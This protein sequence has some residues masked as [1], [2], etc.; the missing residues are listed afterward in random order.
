MRRQRQ[1]RQGLGVPAEPYGFSNNAQ[2][3][4]RPPTFDDAAM[5]L[6]GDSAIRITLILP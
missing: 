1:A 5:V 2:G 4:L 3:F 6:G